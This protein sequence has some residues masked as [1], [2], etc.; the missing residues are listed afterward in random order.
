MKVAAILTSHVMD[1][2]CRLPGVPTHDWCD[3]AGAALTRIHHPA[4]VV[5]TLGRVDPRGFVTNIELVGVAASDERQ[6]VASPHADT[7]LKASSQSARADQTAWQMLA[8]E[9]HLNHVKSHVLPSE[10]LGWNI[11]TLNENLWFVSTASQQGLMPGRGPGPLSKRWDWLTPTDVILG[12]V[13]VPGG[14]SGRMLFIEIASNDP[15]FRESSRE[16]AV[17]AATLPMLSQRVCKAFGAEAEDRMAWLTP[18]EEVVMWH[19]VAG[20]KVPQIAELLHRSIYTVH[21]HVKS[22]HR[23]LNANNRGQLVARALGHLGPIDAETQAKM[24]DVDTACAPDA[25]AA[26]LTPRSVAGAATRF[27]VDR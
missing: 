1:S 6:A 19:L 18:R 25:D 3:R 5:S 11:G 13:T 8:S 20:L 2:V 12:A 14:S 26:P 22:L 23:K 21:D 9:R 15:N 10:W 16:Q 7:M 24:Q 4:V 17:L 27:G